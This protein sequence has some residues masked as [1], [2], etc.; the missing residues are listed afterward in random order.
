MIGAVCSGLLAGCA[1]ITT[2]ERYYLMRPPSEG[3]CILFAVFIEVEEIEL[4]GGLENRWTM[5]LR[6]LAGAKKE[7]AI[8]RRNQPIHGGNDEKKG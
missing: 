1:A 6:D 5:I 4:A 7:L 2:I 8:Y 3:T